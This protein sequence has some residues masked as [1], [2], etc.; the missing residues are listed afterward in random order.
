MTRL[1]AHEHVR[2]PAD[3]LERYVAT[4]LEARRRADGSVHLKL[5]VPSRALDHV[6]LSLEREVIA[7]VEVGPDPS[8]L[9][10]VLN[11]SWEPEGGGPYPSFSGMLAA[12][13][14]EGSESDSLLA[15]DGRYKPPG[16]A[17][18]RAFDEAFGLAIARSSARALL[19]QLRDDA[20]AA[21]RNETTRSG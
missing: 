10:R 1:L 19:E 9:N 16:G 21:Y 14:V 15:L 20:E 18:G 4:Y 8:G 3:R 7:T 12:E 17:P 2:C 11:V 13:P 5:G 6:G